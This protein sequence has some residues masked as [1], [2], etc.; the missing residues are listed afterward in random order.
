M[1]SKSLP[2]DLRTFLAR[3]A[4]NQSPSIADIRDS[5]RR[6]RKARLLM[7]SDVPVREEAGMYG[8]FP[9]R[10]MVHFLDVHGYE[11]DFQGMAAESGHHEYRCAVHRSV[12]LVDATFAPDKSRHRLR[13]HGGR[14]YYCERCDV[15]SP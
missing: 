11:V 2:E 5:T 7:P 8:V 1:S 12:Q 3:A 14:E 10:A 4:Q 13:R 15:E 6:A 9:P